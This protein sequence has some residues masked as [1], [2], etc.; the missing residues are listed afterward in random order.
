MESEEYGIEGETGE[1]SVEPIYGYKICYLRVINGTPQ[2][3]SHTL[4]LA[5]KVD[6][7]AVCSI[8]E[9]WA[10]D[11][12][13]NCG[14]HLYKTQESAETETNPDFQNV[15][16]KVVGSGRYFISRDMY[17]CSHQ[18]VESI[19][20]SGC[21][22]PT[23]TKIP[24]AFVESNNGWLNGVCINHSTVA[25]SMKLWTLGAVAES[26]SSSNNNDNVRR[27]V[28]VFGAPAKPGIETPQSQQM[29]VDKQVS[30]D[31]V[32]MLKTT[33]RRK[34]SWTWKVIPEIFVMMGSMTLI[35]LM[36]GVF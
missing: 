25:D 15:I 29:R 7:D 32:L 34:G 18:R 4:R 19:T 8:F 21:F 28:E 33:K 17:K 9:H 14:F 3:V 26:L 1:I 30:K 13:C 2:I 20:V 24:I 12:D 31:P 10:P 35:L 23:C 36:M 11:A 22:T 27:Q 5:Y 6:A 16:L